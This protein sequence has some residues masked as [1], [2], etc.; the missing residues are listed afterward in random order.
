MTL[1][2]YK[3]KML[4][5]DLMSYIMKCIHDHKE[6]KTCASADGLLCEQLGD[7]DGSALIS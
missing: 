7:V 5:D 6:A 1:T 3:D 4:S 2:D